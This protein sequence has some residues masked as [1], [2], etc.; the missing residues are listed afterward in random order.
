VYAKDLFLRADDDK[1]KVGV[2]S[3]AGTLALKHMARDD[4]ANT[5]G[6]FISFGLP[7]PDGTLIGR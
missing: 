7:P 4:E 3:T 5:V 2:E 1:D 6:T